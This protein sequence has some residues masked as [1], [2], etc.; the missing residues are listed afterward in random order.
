MAP[1]KTAKTA[2]TAKTAKTA[3][4][5]IEMIL[6]TEPL[7]TIDEAA[8]YVGLSGFE[9]QNQFAETLNLPQAL[10]W[11]TVPQEHEHLL[12]E[13]KAQLQNIQTMPN[14]SPE[15]LPAPQ[16]EQQLAPT[17][18]APVEQP[19]KLAKP[20]GT[21]LTQG[22]RK[23]LEE[24][25]EKSKELN[26]SKINVKDALH[27]RKGQKSGARAATIELAAEDATYRKIM[28]EGLKRK[29]AQLVAEVATEQDLDPIQLL[30][31]LGI[32]SNSTILD[33]LRS[34]LVPTLGNV[35]SAVTEILDSAWLNG[36]SLDEEYTVLSSLLNSEE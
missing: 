2:E 25:D 32:D 28:S 20:K 29:T 9:L 3:E 35:D 12:N 23:K 33:D 36:I 7:K 26:T 30:E 16:T 18:E 6:S 4:Q 27:A 11:E 21:K 14:Q 22:K 19:G 10:T 5:G 34:E 17:P 15:A 1:R 31:E 8:Q 24:S 13:F